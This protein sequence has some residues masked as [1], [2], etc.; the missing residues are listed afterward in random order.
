MLMTLSVHYPILYFLYWLRESGEHL[1]VSIKEYTFPEFNRS[2][3]IITTPKVIYVGCLLAT[4]IALNSGGI[5]R[6]ALNAIS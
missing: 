4:E 6:S 5:T 2:Y 1:A 3:Y